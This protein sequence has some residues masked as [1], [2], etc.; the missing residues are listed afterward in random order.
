MLTSQLLS[1]SISKITEATAP[2]TFD[3]FTLSEMKK[4]DEKIKG[5]V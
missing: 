4:A 2:L 1:S 5:L 3:V